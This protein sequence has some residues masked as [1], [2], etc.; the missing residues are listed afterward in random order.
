LKEVVVE[1]ET[2]F[3]GWLKKRFKAL[4]LSYRELG[5][6]VGYSPETIKKIVAGERTFS[7]ET[8]EKLIEVINKHFN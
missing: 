6:F 1:G 4:G 2:S 7:P 8:A 5:N 3:G